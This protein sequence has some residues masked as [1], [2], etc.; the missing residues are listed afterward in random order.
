MWVLSVQNQIKVF[1][2]PGIEKKNNAQ[3]RVCRNV[4]QQIIKRQVS[5]SQCSWSDSVVFKSS[6]VTIMH[7]L[8]N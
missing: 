5:P 4:S 2:F 3:C 8:I 6:I 7:I 1:L